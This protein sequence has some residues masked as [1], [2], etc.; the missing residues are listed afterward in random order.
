HSQTSSQRPQQRPG[1]LKRLRL[2]V[3]RTPRP[4][5]PPAP[6]TT[7]SS[8]TA[9]P[10]FQARLRHLLTSQPENAAPHV[11]DVAYAQGSRAQYCAGCSKPQR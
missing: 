6:P 8:T 10:T 1:C 11:V 4:A 9:P 3:T 5:P 7:Q 2:A